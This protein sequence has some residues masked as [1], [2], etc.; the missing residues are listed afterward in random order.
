MKIK[1][2]RPKD[3]EGLYSHK[4]DSFREL[5]EIWEEL[6]YVK[7]IDSDCKHVWMNYIGDILLYDRPTLEWLEPEL[8]YNLGLFGNPELPENG[9]NNKHWIFWARHPKILN[10]DLNQKNEFNTVFIGNIENT[11]QLKYRDSKWSEVLDK[12]ELTIGKDYKYD[13]LEYLKIISRSKYG[14]CLR[15]YGSK[16]HR[17]IE[18][19]RYGTVPIFTPECNTDYYNQ[20]QENEHFLR[21]STPE[22]LQQKLE[23]IESDEYQKLSDNCKEWYKINCS[24]EGSFKVTMEI[25]KTVQKVKEQN[26]LN[27]I[28]TMV[29][30]GSESD[31]IQLMLSIKQNYSDINV[32]VLCDSYIKKCFSYSQC[33]FINKLDKYQGL[34]REQMEEKDIWVE[35]MLKKTDIIDYAL[36]YNHNSL[37][38]DSDVFFL[39]NKLDIDYTKQ[40]GLSPH[41]ISDQEQ[42]IYG[43]YNAGFIYISDQEVTKYWRDADHSKYYLEQ[44]I[45]N[46]FPKNF[47]YFEFDELN[48][49]G[50][51]RINNVDNP[52]EIKKEISNNN[53]K[54]YFKEQDI[55]SLHIH[56]FNNKY[57]HF[58]DI[59]NLPKFTLIIQYY[60]DKNS[61]RQN[62][63]DECLENNLNNLLFKRVINLV[64]NDIKVPEKF[65]N[66]KKYNEVNIGKRVTYKDIIEYSNKNLEYEL[67][68]FGNLD[69]KFSNKSDL[70]VSKNEVV[71]LSR[72][73][74]N[75]YNLYGAMSSQDS[76]V[77]IPPININNC[78][79]EI[80]SLGCDNAFADRVM[81]SGYY[82][83]N[84]GV[85]FLNYHIDNVRT[86]QEKKELYLKNDAMDQ[87]YLLLPDYDNLSK[88][89]VTNNDYKL[90][91]EYINQVLSNQV[92]SN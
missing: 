76:W 57:K 37:F 45:L 85:K 25:V 20:L 10:Q 40:V 59:F 9:Q 30:R 38:V 33:I 75:Q 29:T 3:Q 79:F 14:L 56:Q 92:L 68:V 35:F 60:N 78:D 34:N 64:E 7:V 47:S 26:E 27:S 1:I 54:Y 15:G 71:A 86:L 13:N 66:H 58:I 51:W 72:V 49:F 70:E 21:V 52:D 91:L 36:Q 18:L 82:I 28:S 63:L 4:N 12:Y 5:I 73:E 46:T 88:L 16:C 62:E 11:V 24:P 31:F 61:K 67:V 8:K 6:D 19:M 90:K 77:F 43:K 32:Y 50:F 23:I 81:K 80:G 53:G 65:K 41:Y 39:N 42:E 74:N 2:Y 83:L 48:N 84:R 89:D 87:G 44:G 17:E 22:E 55:N 69:I